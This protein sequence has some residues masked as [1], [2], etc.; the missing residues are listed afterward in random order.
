MVTLDVAIDRL[1]EA[2]TD[3]APTRLREIDGALPALPPGTWYLN[4]PGRFEIA[5]RTYG[6]WL[7]GDGLVRALAFDESGLTFRSRFVRTRKFNE[8]ACA[9]RSLF[10]AF[11]SAEPGDALNARQTGLESPANVSIVWHGGALLALGEQGQ[12]W[13]I[14]PVTLE[15]I[16][17]HSA[18]GAITGITP[19]AA[20]GKVDTVTGEL[21]NFGVSFS[22]DRPLLNLFRFDAGGCQTL[23]SRVPLPYSCT[24]HDFA[25]GPAHAAFYITP[26]LLDMT[27]LRAGGSVMDAL[28]WRPELGSR[29]LLV[30]RT[31]G[32]LV[33]SIDVG[34]R[35]CLHTINCF[36]D[37]DLVVLDVIEMS[38]P[39]YDAYAVPD[40]FVRPID[41]VPVRL[42]IDPSGQRLVSRTPLPGARAPEFPSL[43]PRD[44]MRAYE[45][46][47]ALGMSA[48]DRS[49]TK[50]FDQLV[51]YRW[52]APEQCDVYTAPAHQ[53]LGGEPLVVGGEGRL[54]VLCQVFDG[55][56]GRSGFLVFAARDV[57]SG[58]VACVWLPAPTPMAFHGLYLREQS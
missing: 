9:G 14:D 6:H 7:D 47:W 2:G 8:E 11:G 50:F 39:V 32:S 45:E 52:H 44:A 10:R 16:G 41:A 30:A 17:P 43:D 36:A 22:P 12:P 26:Y 58:P 24:I 38:R 48:G 13:R 56:R 23:R 20:H 29:V 31:S 18:Y 19:F 40:I 25:L 51:R 4:G 42:V 35:Y 54:W 33:A 46:F 1:F 57:A 34:E 21:F 53:R 28:S 27:R 55:A 3:V 37:G 5:G 49:G 15:T